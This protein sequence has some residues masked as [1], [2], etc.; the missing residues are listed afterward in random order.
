[1]HTDQGIQMCA[2]QKKTPSAHS[3]SYAH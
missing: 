3:A 2:A 1:M